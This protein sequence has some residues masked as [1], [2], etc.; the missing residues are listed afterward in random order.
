M[1][2]EDRIHISI[3]D[4]MKI[5]YPKVIFTSEPSGL[6]LPIGLATKLARMRSGSKLLDIWIPEPSGKYHGLFLEVKADTPFKKDGSL[7]AGDH[8]KEQAEMI[9]RLKKKGYQ[10]MFVWSLEQAV[11]EVNKYMK[12]L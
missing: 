5:Q 9:E 8:L 3:C 7:Y 10:A 2:P 6:R 1:R 12:G 11:V 4:W